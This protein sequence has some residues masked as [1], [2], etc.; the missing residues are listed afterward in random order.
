MKLKRF[1][2][3]D[4]KKVGI[5]I[6]TVCCVLFIAGVFFF[7]SFALFET[8]QDFN[9]IR[10]NVEDSGDLYFTFYVDGVI[11]K[12]MPQKEDNYFFERGVCNNGATVEFNHESWAPEI[13]NMTKTHTKCTLYFKTESDINHA[14]IAQL[15]TTGSCPTVNANGTVNA[16][17]L[18]AING[19]LCSAKDDYGTSYYY[20]GNVT[21]NYVKFGG[22]YWRIIRINGD[23][24][25]RMIYAG[26]ASVIDALDEATKQSVLVNGYNDSSTKYTQI[27]ESLF[28][29]SWN[30]NAY[31]GYM[32][33][34]I[35]GTTYK[36]VHTN[37]TSSTI[38][39][40]VD[41]W[42]QNHLANTEYEQYISNTLF[43]N[44]RSISPYT[45][46]GYLNTG[47]GQDQTAYR[48][49]YRPWSDSST[50]NN[51][52]LGCKEQND[53]FTRDDTTLGNGALTYPIGL[54]TMDE[55][56]LAGGYGG[57]I[58]SGYYLY[59]GYNYWTISPV[60]FDAS[61]PAARVWFVNSTGFFDYNSVGFSHGVRPIINLK[62]GS[63]NSGTGVRNDPYKI[64]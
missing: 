31:V 15:D 59:T 62:A 56:V 11:S 22:F 23:G 60:H 52:T 57:T 54:I 20:R 33:G 10:G 61:G 21:N 32:Y 50:K 8:H 29:E 25:I 49:Y 13:Q 39:T 63:L 1:K 40:T 19:Y 47:I 4:K 46:D 64:A 48:W 5:I 9:V 55:L 30:N 14:I 53:R 58:N 44:D 17:S 24:S 3:K 18:E 51:L 26:D 45:S 7:Q 42:Y 34:N 12:T 38:K 6:F 35:S 43:C 27:G 36:E 16:T 2:E 28:N 41:A 37:T